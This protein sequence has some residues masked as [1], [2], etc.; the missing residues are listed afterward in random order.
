MSTSSESQP[1]RVLAVVEDLRGLVAACRVHAPL[2]TLKRQGVVSDYRVTDSTLTGV[3]AD[4]SFDVL[5]IQRAPA[6]RLAARLVTRFAHQYLHDMD[7]LLITTPAYIQAGELP[8][9]DALLAVADHAAVFTAPSGR[10]VRLMEKHGQ[11]S[12]A[13]RSVICPNA[14]ELPAYGARST[15]PPQGLIFTQSHRLALTESREDVLGAVRRFVRRSR[16]PLY[17]FGPPPDVLGEGVADLL[18]PVVACGY[19]DFWRYHALLA[20]WPSMIGVAPLETAGDAA[21]IDF[22]AAK[23]DVK[24]VEFAGFG[25]PAVYSSAAPFTDTDLRAGRVVANNEGEWGEA[26][27][28]TLEAG[29]RYASDEQSQMLAAR[30]MERIAAECW[31]PALLASRLPESRR[32]GELETKVRWTARIR[33]VGRVPFKN[34]ETM[35]PA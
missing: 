13:G 20:A 26:L 25:H 33:G 28:Q 5:W 24:M 32:V 10:F 16:L 11:L 3:P 8:D 15:A 29:W 27:A 17:Y 21:T 35:P 19:L 14:L 18:G 31:R 7:D 30:S 6:T 34:R 22:V 2:M 9:R 4:F 1:L 23:S 12:F